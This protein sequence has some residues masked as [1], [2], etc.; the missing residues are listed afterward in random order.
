MPLVDKNNEYIISIL[1]F[2]YFFLSFSF[3]VLQNLQQ[4]RLLHIL[5]NEMKMHCGQSITVVNIY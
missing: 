4:L 5:K 2:S 3:K 1:E